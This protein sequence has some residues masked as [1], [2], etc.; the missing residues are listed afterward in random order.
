ML[1]LL[2]HRVDGINRLLNGPII[3]NHFYCMP[4]Q[5][6]I[7]GLHDHLHRFSLI[8][9]NFEVLG[10]E[11]K[12]ISGIAPQLHHTGHPGIREIYAELLNLVYAD[13][14]QVDCGLELQLRFA[15]ISR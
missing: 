7:P 10:A 2:E 13:M 9:A 3:N 4:A 8:F 1:T 11:R 12:R 5:P 6:H 15:G 14:A